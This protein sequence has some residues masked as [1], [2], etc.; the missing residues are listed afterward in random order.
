MAARKALPAGNDDRSGQIARL[1]DKAKKGDKTAM[2]ELRPLLA[3]SPGLLDDYGKLAENT[4]RSLIR[5]MSGDNLLFQEG[6]LQRLSSLRME[7]SG[8]VPSPLEVLLV[9]RILTCWLEVQYYDAL[10]AQN[11]KDLNLR[12]GDYYQRRQDRAHMRFLSAV[13]SLA[14]IRRLQLP[15]VQV[16]IGEK[17]VNVVTPSGKLP[18]G[19]PGSDEGR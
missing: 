19:S 14:M 11:M 6:V 2:G 10:Y 17:Q 4:Q 13:K 18:A 12:Q 8:M 7:L 9:E 3:S 15:V 1:M 5:N 16:N